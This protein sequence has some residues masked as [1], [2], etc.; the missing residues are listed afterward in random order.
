MSRISGY[1]SVNRNVLS[2]VRKVAGDGADE[3]G[4]RQ[5][6]TWGLATEKY[7]ATNSG[8]VNWGL[9]EAVAAGKRS[10]RR[11]GSWKV[12]NVSEWA[13]VRRCTAVEDL[14]HQD[15]ILGR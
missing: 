11:L 1:G 8:I 14:V 4:G 10:P 6:H 15:G 5:F 2:R 13:K 3:I 12:G 7:S 9:N